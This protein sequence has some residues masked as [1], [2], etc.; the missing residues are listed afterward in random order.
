MREERKELIGMG[1]EA[2]FMGRLMWEI[3]YGGGM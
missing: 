2:L 1:R 3:V